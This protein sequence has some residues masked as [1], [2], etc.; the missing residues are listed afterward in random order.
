MRLLIHSLF[1]LLIAF[2]LHSENTFYANFAL[3][4]SI[5]DKKITLLA[6]GSLLYNFSKNYTISIG[7][8]N[9]I[10]RNLK[11]NF[12]DSVTQ[13]KPTFEYN[14]FSAAFEYIF[15]PES[16]VN[17]SIQAKFSLGHIKYNLIS[18][19]KNLVTGYNPDYSED[20]FFAVEPNVAIKYNWRSWAKF[21]WRLGYRLPIDVSYSY[22]AS[23]YKND[24]FLKPYT[25]ICLEIGN[26]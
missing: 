7:S 18:I 6:G 20:W 25:E 17:Y 9:M 2:S 21:V 19:E 3:N 23:T 13:I 26:F 14:Y 4:P 8:Y 10:S 5:I 11:A 15:N 12:I 16:L 22:G 24:K 1:F